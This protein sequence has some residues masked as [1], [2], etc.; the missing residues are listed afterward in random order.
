[1]RMP[2]KQLM[3]RLE[4]FGLCSRADVRACEP[5]VA[6]MCS[7]LPDFDSI[8]LDALV[9]EKLLTRYQ[10]QLLSSPAARL[11]IGDHLLIRNRLGPYTCQ[12]LDRRS[13]SFVAIREL[14]LTAES[15][16]S[17][18]DRLRHLLTSLNTREQ[19]PVPAIVLPAMILSDESRDGAPPDTSDGAQSISAQGGPEPA[20]DESPDTTVRVRLDRH[21]ALQTDISP[22]RFD[23]VISPWVDGWRLNELMIRGGRLP[24][25]AVAEIG[26]DLLQAIAWLES[27]RLLHGDVVTSHVILRPS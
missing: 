1:M 21:V 10:A 11:L 26:R 22:D 5:L 24:W 27:A 3:E 8:W 23:A 16:S 19:R 4:R 25:S 14:N 20:V 9:Q 6:R 15:R 17:G 18:M 13:G 7:D 12:A 2:S